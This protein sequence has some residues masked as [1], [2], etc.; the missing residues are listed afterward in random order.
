[1]TKL[2]QTGTFR[3]KN[4]ES[5]NFKAIKFFFFS[6]KDIIKFNLR[7]PKNLIFILKYCFQ[8]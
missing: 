6:Q 2:K 8:K 4:I 7:T 5:K 1:M 3:D